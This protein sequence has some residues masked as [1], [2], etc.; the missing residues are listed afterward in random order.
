MWFQIEQKGD[1]G[2]WRPCG[3]LHQSVLEA[4]K[5]IDRM[6]KREGAARSRLRVIEQTE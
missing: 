5:E 2:Q 6:V 3:I 4:L 1:D